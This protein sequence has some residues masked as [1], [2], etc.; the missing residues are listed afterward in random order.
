[1]RAFKA[2]CPSCPID[3]QSGKNVSYWREGSDTKNP[4]LFVK[5]YELINARGRQ[6][7]F[8]LVVQH[9]TEEQLPSSTC[10]TGMFCIPIEG[11]CIGAG[12]QQ[13]KRKGYVILVRGNTPGALKSVARFQVDTIVLP[14]IDEIRADGKWIPG[15]PFKNKWRFKLWTDAEQN[16]ISLLY[17]TDRISTLTDQHGIDIMM[18]GCNT[19]HI[20]QAC[21]LWKLFKM[22][23][24]AGRAP[25]R[26]PD[27]EEHFKQ[28]LLAPDVKAV[29]KLD[30]SFVNTLARWLPV[31][32]AVKTRC[33]IDSVW[34]AFELG[35]HVGAGREGL[36]PSV[37]AM[38][39]TMRRP[40]TAEEGDKLRSYAQ[41]AVKTWHKTGVLS[42]EW[43]IECG[44]RRDVDVKGN[45][46]ARSSDASGK[47]YQRSQALG[48]ERQRQMNEAGKAAKEAQ[49]LRKQ[50]DVISK[51]SSIIAD[52]KAL[53]DGV[54][55][56]VQTRNVDQGDYGRAHHSP[57]RKRLLSAAKE[58]D[59]EA[60]LK[61]KKGCTAQH[62]KAFISARQYH[63][64][65]SQSGF[66]APVGNMY[67]ATDRA[68]TLIEQAVR[69]VT[70]DVVMKVPGPP[71]GTPAR[72]VSDQRIPQMQVSHA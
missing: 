44:F 58:A 57:S 50:Q 31:Y 30:P 59:F 51:T 54:M 17:D 21:D 33:D 14:M 49:V 53:E 72:Q 20:R 11:F 9:L 24:A 67:K 64:V 4:H 70:S 69:L 60:V 38:V 25:K 47:S 23:K 28:A 42:D 43:M 40:L 55:A 35:G 5:A 1:M 16:F 7:D 19:T 15:M 66:R 45:D 22:L 10:P 39:R 62:V 3:E 61:Q 68:P 32:C 36:W 48:H 41:Q 18:H 8:M 6:S 46:I 27:L 13:N 29:V 2:L 65:S 34:H 26:N 56:E 71:A 12:Q 63:D 37:P 52:N